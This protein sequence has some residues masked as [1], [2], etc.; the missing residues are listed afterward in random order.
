MVILGFTLV[1]I[2]LGMGIL[3]LTLGALIHTG[4]PS[5]EYTQPLPRKGAVVV[6]L[7]GKRVDVRA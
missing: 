6:C 2:A 3:A 7:V 4:N 1:G 5:T